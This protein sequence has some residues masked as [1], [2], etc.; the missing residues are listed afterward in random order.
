M[1]QNVTNYYSGRLDEI[2]A[3]NEDLARWVPDT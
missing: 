2:V 3:R 1:W